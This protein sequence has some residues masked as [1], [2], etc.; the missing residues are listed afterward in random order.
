[1]PNKDFVL[2]IRKLDCN[3][4]NI[5]VL[6]NINLDVRRG[7]IVALIGANGAG[8]TTLMRTISGLKDQ[9]KGDIIFKENIVIRKR[10]NL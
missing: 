10:L 9:N 6:Q 5:Q 8:K 2:E 3:Y 7:E 1:M 4:G